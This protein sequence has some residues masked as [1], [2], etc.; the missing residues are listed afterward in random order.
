MNEGDV[1][2]YF[3]D[4]YALGSDPSA[5]LGEKIEQAITI[6]R[7]RLGLDYGVLSYTGSGEYEVMGSTIE[8]GEYAAG[9]VYD[10]ETTW[11]RHVV[12]D[13]RILMIADANNSAYKDD[14]ARDV[15]G[16][17][18][19]IGAPIRLD[20][21]IFGTLC[22][23]ADEPRDTDFGEDEQHF[24]ELLTRWIGYELERERHYEAL[25]VQNDRL[26]EFAGV[27]AHDLRNPLTGARGYTELAAESVS[28][29]EAEYLETVL[30]SL[31]RM[32]TLI[33]ETL[34]LAREGED[35]GEREP[36]QLSSVVRQAWET[37]SPKTATLEIVN[38]RV[39]QADRSRV[40]QLFENLFRNVEEHCGSG[41]SVTVEGTSG[42][43]AVEDTGPGLPEEIAKSLFSDRYG[44]GRRGLGLLIVERIVSGHGWNGSVTTS[45]AGT[46][47]EFSDIGTVTEASRPNVSG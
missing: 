39:I 4:L 10:L 44:D 35:V 20:G 24:V 14:V 22:F 36:V 6:G 47:F 33:T 5:S 37:I 40:R 30:E 34:S 11:C 15:T 29:P 9:S 7:D 17:Q 19:Y 26:N 28:D 8:S 43:F 45:S 1:T 42:G 3:Q 46:R 21:E 38:D 31:D 18:C 41:V 2:D 25:D 27:L 12:D 16:L 13:E 32:E 23:S